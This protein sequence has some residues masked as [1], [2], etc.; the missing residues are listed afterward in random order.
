MSEQVK[1]TSEEVEL[2]TMHGFEMLCLWSRMISMLPLEDW[3]NALNKAE[4]IA[5]ITDPTLYG[6]Y[7]YSEK[8][9]IL[10]EIMEAAIPLKRVVMKHQPSVKPPEES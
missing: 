8:A 1:M 9:K 2:V 3:L 4:T 5:P 6:E 7:L 10:K